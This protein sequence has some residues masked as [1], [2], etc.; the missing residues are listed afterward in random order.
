MQARLQRSILSFDNQGS[1]LLRNGKLD[2]IPHD[3][4]PTY[5]A[6]ARVP[7]QTLRCQAGSINENAPHVKQ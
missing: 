2:H 1:D 4:I 6:V 5:Q 3:E 7:D